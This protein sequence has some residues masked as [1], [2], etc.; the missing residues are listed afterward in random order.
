MPFTQLLKFAADQ[1][2]L[3][4]ALLDQFSGLQN[5]HQPR[6]GAQLVLLIP[7]ADQVFGELQFP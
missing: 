4:L 7:L 1:S 2:L 5:M 6:V 3:C